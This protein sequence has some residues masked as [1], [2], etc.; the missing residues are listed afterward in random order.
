MKGKLGKI[1]IVMLALALGLG[2]LGAG[3]AYW[4]E[5]QASYGW[6]RG[7]DNDGNNSNNSHHWWYTF[8]YNWRYYFNNNYKSVNTDSVC[9]KF[10]DPPCGGDLS[11]D[12]AG[13]NDLI[14]DGVFPFHEIQQ[15]PQDVVWEL[16]FY[17]PG[18]C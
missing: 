7:F 10:V 17:E 14:L 5:S 1:G 2:T 4:S 18:H 6:G 8:I 12:P 3:F 16:T 9:V 15:A 11:S 13:T